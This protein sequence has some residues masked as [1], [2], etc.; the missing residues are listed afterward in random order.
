MILK[1]V[2]K[3][4]VMLDMPAQTIQEPQITSTEQDSLVNL[5]FYEPKLRVLG[6][7]LD[8]LNRIQ[9]KITHQLDSLK[10]YTIQVKKEQRQSDLF[11]GGIIFLFIIIFVKILYINRKKKQRP[12]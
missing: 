9:T 8:S 1:M 2:S 6:N 3:T 11:N 12:N 10:Q 5:E 4:I 7:K